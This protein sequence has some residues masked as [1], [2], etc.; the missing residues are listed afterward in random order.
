MKIDFYINS[1]LTFIKSEQQAQGNFLSYSFSTHSPS[2]NTLE[3]TFCTSLILGCLQ[4]I[5]KSPEINQIIDPAVNFLLSQRNPD[6]SW[7][8]YPLH[9]ND[10]VVSQKDSVE[11][12][13]SPY[14]ND[15]DDTACALIAI[16]L[17]RKG[18]LSP[19]I[20]GA[21][22]KLLVK[23]ESKPGGP[24]Y[25]W[26]LNEQTKDWKDIDPVV[27][28]N[29]GYFLKLHNI[30][31]PPLEKYIEDI[32]TSNNYT[33]R[34]YH[35][36]ESII[37][38]ISRYYSGPLS[39]NLAD[40][41]LER[42]N[43][44]G[45]W[46][47]D[48]VTA[49]AVSSLIRANINPNLFSRAICHLKEIAIK[50]DWHSY[51]L[52]IESNKEATLY[53]GAPALTAAFV[54]EALTLWDR[55]QNNA[56]QQ[57]LK[58]QNTYPF[59]LNEEVI[60]AVKKRL[61]LFPEKTILSNDSLLTKMLAKDPSNQITLLPYFFSQTLTSK[62]TLSQKLLQI[63]GEA[64]LYGWLAY[65]IYDNILDNDSGP[66]LL[67]IANTC[68]RELV[69][70]YTKI[71]PPDGLQLFQDLMDKME[72]ANAW[73]Y[74]HN[75]ITKVKII[76]KRNIL[77]YPQ[78]LLSDKSLPHAFGPISILLKIGFNLNAP[79]IQQTLSFF[80]NYLAARQLND[81]AHDWQED[82]NKGFLNSVSY[83]LLD[84]YFKSHPKLTTL[85]L[86]NKKSSLQKLFWKSHIFSVAD[87]INT[88]LQNAQ[89]ALNQLEHLQIINDRKYFEKLLKPLKQ[90][91]Q[92]IISNQKE[93]GSFLTSF[94][95]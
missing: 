22:T 33:S 79:E 67:P 21:I 70:L 18:I 11:N 38:F 59:K 42:Q 52:Y 23:T 91:T 16:S 30:S 69:T 65:T 49:L 54:L 36:P 2:E 17:N 39:K 35:I 7:N 8:Y 50:N 9:Q 29:I 31:L 51:P 93:I 48:L 78:N 81:D 4:Y 89:A 72:Q 58:K 66:E 37:H 55:R 85:N 6:W 60:T 57:N 28:A 19:E 26:M 32:I 12:K 75:K 88:Y 90:S 43:K 56:K 64:N 44:K 40:Y 84:T 77:Q 61:A 1:I 27:N 10:G 87:E 71:L 80:K 3:N 92:Q 13:S 46:E 95:S 83:S 74:I 45:L 14:P 20:F 82:L 15:W 62:K 76:T 86:L 53:N 24:Y 25:T 5:D 63:L 94:Q 73:E 34:Y 68:L 41:L 47:N